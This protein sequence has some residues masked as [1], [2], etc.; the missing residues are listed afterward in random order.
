MAPGCCGCLGC[1]GSFAGPSSTACPT[2]AA[3]GGALSR[4]LAHT[5]RNGGLFL[6]CQGCSAGRTRWVPQVFISDNLR[7]AGIPTARPVRCPDYLG[8]PQLSMAQSSLAN[9]PG[10]QAGGT[11][12]PA[13][14]SAA[15]SPSPGPARAHW[16]SGNLE[17]LWPLR[18]R[19][20]PAHCVPLRAPQ[21]F[22]GHRLRLSRSVP[23][24]VAL[25]EWARILCSMAGSPLVGF[26]APPMPVSRRLRRGPARRAS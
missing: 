23:G 22:P 11:M 5:S 20:S 12:T 17:S 26:C 1:C 4:A 7:T 13:R 21:A 24:P 16:C 19:I 3:S 8:G 15:P 14:H 25:S 18:T 6:G 2:A 10:A 9:W